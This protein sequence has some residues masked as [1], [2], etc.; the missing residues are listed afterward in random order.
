ML[1]F[2]PELPFDRP[3]RRI[4]AIAAMAALLFPSGSGA[5][6]TIRADGL[7]DVDGVPFF[8]IGLI[9]LGHWQ[10][11]TDWNDRIRQSKANIV[12]DIGVAYADTIPS[13]AALMDS[14]STTGYKLLV[15]SGDTWQWDDPATPELEVDKQMYEDADIPGLEACLGAAPGLNLGYINRDE[16]VWTIPRNQ[17]GD[18]DFAH[19]HETYDQLHQDMNADFVAMNFGSV[20]LSKDLATWKAD[21]S[22]YLDATDIVMHASYPYPSGPG[23]CSSYNVIDGTNCS[24]DRLVIGNNIILNELNKPGQPLWAVIQA[25]KGIPLKELRWEAHAAIVH[26]ATGLFWGGWTWNHVLGNGVDMWD[27]TVQVMNETVALERFLVAPDVTALSNHPDVEVR[28]KKSGREVAVFAIARNGYVGNATITLPFLPKKRSAV[29]VA[30][31]QRFLKGRTGTITDHFNGYE[32]HVYVYT[33]G[34]RNAMGGD[35]SLARGFSMEAFPNP[36]DGRTVVRFS[37]PRD[38]VTMFHV[39][40]TGGRRVAALG[41]G[42]WE[43]GRSEIVWNGRDVQGDRVAPGVY[44]VRGQTADGETATARVVMR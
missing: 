18:I 8:P 2:P 29:A 24:M 22:S 26:G 28:A 36:T 21:V 17:V 41:R 3:A 37:L 13:C 1:G 4:V 38:A 20:H 9:D 32:S 5:T 43:A 25:F 12:W 7:L 35:I 10:Y 44:F 33:S 19:V 31:E 6:S 34:P 40:D 15:G 11:P 42:A 30:N 23:T 27:T 39:Y 16:P 14:A